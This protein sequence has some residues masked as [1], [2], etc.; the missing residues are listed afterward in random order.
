MKNIKNCIFVFSIFF[1]TFLGITHSTSAFTGSV[2]LLSNGGNCNL[3]GS[4]DISTKTCILNDDISGP[5]TISGNDITLD[6]NNHIL[7]MGGSERTGISVS[8][9]SNVTIKNLN[10]EYFTNS[11]VFQSVS[12]STIQN[13]KINNPGSY[14]LFMQGGSGNKFLDSTITGGYM[15]I[16]TDSGGHTI[17][18]NIFTNISTSGVKL[19]YQKASNILIENNIFEKNN[20][21]IEAQYNKN[22]IIKGNTFKNNTGPGYYESGS[23]ANG[24]IIVQNNFIGNG[25][26]WNQGQTSYWLYATLSQ[27]LP[28]GGNY[29]SDF[30]SPLEGCDDINGDGVCDLPRIINN[31]NK[32]LLPWIIENGWMKKPEPANFYAEI[33]NANNVVIMRESAGISEPA[34]KTLPNSFVVYIESKTDT[35]GLPVSSDGFTWY[36]VSDPTDNGVG[37]IPAKIN[38][39]V[40]F[41]EYDKDKQDIFKNKSAVVLDNKS[42]R[43]DAVIEAVDHYFNNNDIVKSLYSSDDHS[44]KISNLIQKGFPKDLILAIIAQ[45]I[46][47]ENFDNENVSF[48][49]GH[50]M[51][52]ITMS[53]KDD[54]TKNSSDPRGILSDI[55]LSKCRNINPN[56]VDPKYPGLDEYKKC[57]EPLYNSQGKLYANKYSYYDDISTNPK[58]KQYANTIQ[59]IYANIKDGLGILESK[60]GHV[61]SHE[62][63][64]SVI[65]GGYTITCP[66]INIIKAVWGYNGAVLDPN[67]NYLKYI[68]SRL[69]NLSTYY[70]NHSYPN[71]DNLIEKLAIANNNRKEIKVHSPVEL[72]VSDNAGNTTGLVNGEAIANI[73]NSTYDTESESAVIFFHN[74]LYTYKVIGDGTGSS[75][76]MDIIDTVDG[77]N[78]TTL[79]VVDLPISKNEIHTYHIDEAVLALGG[80]GITLDIDTNGDGVIDRTLHTGAVLDDI[81]SPTIILNTNILSEYILDS[82]ISVSVS[83]SD[84]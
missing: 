42:T 68:S 15:G 74:S 67:I 21:G 7:K 43:V 64:N 58:Y 36:K 60:N 40:T 61:F 48:D 55:K 23:G 4:W 47:G 26:K 76:G 44:L 33:K 20:Y 5:I 37:W 80:K 16:W 28:I 57:Y 1:L 84:N 29:W 38:G 66:E 11:I 50:G 59:S 81:I 56:P 53:A 45:E 73:E 78:K 14:G 70:P 19:Y 22:N 83:V 62:C 54:Y 27:D 6:G 82:N 18:G 41:L 3:V 25:I 31:D 52:Q 77:V 30:D 10:I 79:Q 35:N 65:I 12:N 75:Y 39:G 9:S 8:G 69:K 13:V 71:N 34:V 24:T 32:D 51:M 49:Y 17:S 2:S 63:I 46:G 72:Q